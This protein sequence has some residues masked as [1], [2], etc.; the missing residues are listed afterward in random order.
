MQKL[1]QELGKE[2]EPGRLEGSSLE[3]EMMLN[4][5]Q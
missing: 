4:L 1:G 5:E 3:R 2:E